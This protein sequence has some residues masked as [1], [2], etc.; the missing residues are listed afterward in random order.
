MGGNFAPRPSTG[1][2]GLR[3]CLPLILILRNRLRYAL[4]YKEAKSIATQRFIEVDHRIRT[5]FC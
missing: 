2:H 5:D 4:N 1:A 3:E